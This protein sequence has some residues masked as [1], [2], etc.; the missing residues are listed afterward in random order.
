[1]NRRI[2]LSLIAS[3][4]ILATCRSESK[5]DAGK[6]GDAKDVV[7]QLTNEGFKK[8]VFNYDAGREWKYEG[9]MPAIIDFYADWCGPCRQLSP[10]VEEFAK[11]YEGKIIV[12]KVNTDKEPAL[13]KSMGIT[14][15]PSLLFIPVK[16]TPQM[17]MGLLSRESLLKAITDV[18]LVK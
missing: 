1:M 15:L 12:Y 3:T 7:V 4:L 16:G 6:G 14:G 17:S 11:K 18:L 2:V 9:T 8:L 13:S 10:M 5:A